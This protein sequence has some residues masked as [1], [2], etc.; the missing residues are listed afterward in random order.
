MA[1]IDLGSHAELFSTLAGCYVERG[2]LARASYLL[3]E[4]IDET[5]VSGTP[6]EQA[7][8]YWNA[9]VTAVERGRA[10]DGLRLADQATQ[11]LEQWSSPLRWC[12]RVDPS[13]SWG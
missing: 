9:A 12:T 7:Q 11:L 3:D 8:A 5:S 4:L 6:L 1:S 10:A 2:D 13:S